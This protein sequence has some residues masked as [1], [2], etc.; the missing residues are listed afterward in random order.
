MKKY[1][2]IKLA[3]KKIEIECR[4]HYIFHQC[5][6][7]LDS[8]E[9]PDFVVS[10]TEEEIDAER[11]RQPRYYFDRIEKSVLYYDEGELESVVVYR[12]IAEALVH[13]GIIMFHGAAIALN[14]KC[15]IFTAPSGVGKTTH[16]MNWKRAYP[17][18]VIVNGD[19]PLINVYKKIVYGTPWAGKENLNTNTS[20]PFAGIIILNRGEE[21]EIKPI[22]FKQS[23]PY[24]IQQTY[25]P[26]RHE[27]A[28]KTIRLISDISNVPIFDL[29][30][31]MDL[32]SAVAAH[33]GI[34]EYEN[35]YRRVT[36]TS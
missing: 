8:F 5:H 29:K 10:A 27:L 23:I 22:Q 17:D 16:I 4:N 7:Y 34:I 36:S 33:N 3:D 31:N 15:Y 25:L 1:F 26:P 20:I 13:Y 19:K 11:D 21:N 14:N 35:R 32:N 2:R 9:N 18:T 6:E 30:C 12:K 28:I 24:I